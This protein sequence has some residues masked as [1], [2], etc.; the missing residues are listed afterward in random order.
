MTF[1]SQSNLAMKLNMCGR[2]TD[3]KESDHSTLSILTD[4]DVDSFSFQC[5][6]FTIY[7]QYS[8]RKILRC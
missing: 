8:Q 2:E 6:Y 1:L 5:K 7:R 4:L 3:G